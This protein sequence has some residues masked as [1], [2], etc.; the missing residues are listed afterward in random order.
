MPLLA[1]TVKPRQTRQPVEDRKFRP[2]VE[3]L[4]AIAVLLVVLDHAGWAAMSGG[5][6][7][8]DVFFV[9]SGFLITGLL[10]HELEAE[11]GVSLS[12]FYAR[13]ARRLL[14]AGSLV[15]VTTVIASYLYLGEARAQTIAVDAR[16]AALFAS[17]FRFIN[18]GTDYFGSR[19]PPSPL[20]HFWSLAVE[21]QFYAV[22]PALM[23]A[24]AFVA[25][26]VPIRIKLGL[27]L[28]VIIGASLLWS[29]KMTP[30][31]GTVAYFSPFSR[32][33]ELGAGALL[34]VISPWLIPL[35]RL[36]GVVI[37]WVGVVTI[38]ATSFLFTSTTPFPGDAVALPVLATAFAVAGGTIAR[39]GGAELVLK[40]RPFQWIGKLSYSLYLWHWPVLIVAA[41]WTGRDLSLAENL[42]LCL[43]A[44][45]LAAGT[46]VLLEHPVRDSSLLK[47]RPPLASVAV[48]ACLVLF[49]FGVSSWM[50]ESH[51]APGELL[52]KNDRPITFATNAEV[53]KA[54]ADGARVK[55]WPDQPKRIANPAYSKDCNVT[56]KD[57]KSNVC[58]HGDANANRTVVIYGDSHAAMWIPA[59][60]IIGQQQHWQIAQLT[61]PGC[62]VPNY[63]VWS[64]SLKREYTE[65]AEFRQ[66][67]LAKIA[68]LHPDLVIMTSAYKLVPVAVDGHPTND[69]SEEVWDQGLAEMIDRIMPNTRGIIVL[70]D[71][72]YPSKPGI[73]CLSSQ[74]DNVPA[75]NTPRADGVQTEHNENEK[76]IAHERGAQYVD[77]IPWFC[78][79]QVCPAVIAGLTTHRES[80]HVSENYA[81]WLSQVLGEATGLIPEGAK[82]NPV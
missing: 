32:A 82:L 19:L 10:L 71:M 31:D 11:G 65:C 3:G 81:V 66:F 14:P 44:L 6:I 55:S 9:L 17:N 80:Y 69:G 49:T 36:F 77:I 8:V 30:E 79:D 24:I 64:L 57:T 45:A 13:R 18:Q 40:Q 73:D 60:D 7:G 48:G 16:W 2:D 68:E 52:A 38:V 39:G 43:V 62:P 46:F 76:Q 33:C 12:R 28:I 5:F 59:F 51:P 15:L 78:T 50:I 75:C 47:T 58:I 34:A 53:R 23:T 41:G 20:Q 26:R 35:P 25:K 21:E 70:G 63:P 54:V 1:T 61:K 4:R 42:S 29:I 27:A 37:S 67:A 22:W 72:A 74:P 56:R